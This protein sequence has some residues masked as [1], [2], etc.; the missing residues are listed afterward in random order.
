[1]YGRYIVLDERVD[2]QRLAATSGLYS[3]TLLH[4][5]LDSYFLWLSKAEKRRRVCGTYSRLKYSIGYLD[6]AK[7][8]TRGAEATFWA[9]RLTAYKCPCG[10]SGTKAQWPRDLLNIRLR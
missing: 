7:I 9:A 10:A 5:I 2:V 1:M 6:F 8:V 3:T 4:W